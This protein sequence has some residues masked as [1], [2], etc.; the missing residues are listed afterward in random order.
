MK[1][2][3]NLFG[4]NETRKSIQSFAK[5]LPVDAMLMIKG[6]DDDTD[7]TWPPKNGSGN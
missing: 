3:K 2:L 4:K 5:S 1:T 6:G 7:T